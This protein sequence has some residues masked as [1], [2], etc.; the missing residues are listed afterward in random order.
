MPGSGASY[1]E[2]P[3]ADQYSVLRA[4]GGKVPSPMKARAVYHYSHD[5]GTPQR[6]CSQCSMFR[7][8][9]SCTD[10]GGFIAKGGLCDIFDRKK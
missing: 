2:M 8:P 10:V 4:W 6:Q 3:N 1:D 5:R 9:H 7:A